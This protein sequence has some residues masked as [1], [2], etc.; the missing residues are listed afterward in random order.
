MKF[1]QKLNIMLIVY[2]IIRVLL[3]LSL[4]IVIRCFFYNI[5][6]AESITIAFNLTE[7]DNSSCTIKRLIKG[8]GVTLSIIGGL[9]IWYCF[10]TAVPIIISEPSCDTSVAVLENSES[11]REY[12]VDLFNHCLSIL[13]TR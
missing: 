3:L 12:T 6:Q 4:L 2:P 8:I 1:I 11:L 5:V 7:V 9:Y 13:R 10:D